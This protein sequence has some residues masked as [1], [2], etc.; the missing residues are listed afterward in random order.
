MVTISIIFVAVTQ[1]HQNMR[2]RSMSM[3]IHILLLLTSPWPIKETMQKVLPRHHHYLWSA[4]QYSSFLYQLAPKNAMKNFL[5][6]FDS[7]SQRWRI[8]E[9]GKGECA[10]WFHHDI[11]IAW[12]CRSNWQLKDEISTPP[13]AKSVSEWVNE[14]WEIGDWVSNLLTCW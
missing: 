13:P 2:H 10:W 14:E 9:D 3:Y 4:Q 6:K 12:S 5:V 1:R 11:E 8:R 7:I